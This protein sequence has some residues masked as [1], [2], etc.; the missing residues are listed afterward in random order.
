MKVRILPVM[1][2]VGVVL[3]VSTSVF[4]TERAGSNPVADSNENG[5]GYDEVFSDE[6]QKQKDRRDRYICI[7]APGIGAGWLGM[8]W[9]SWLF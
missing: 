6:D 7:E 5:E 2:Y 4:Q 8:H 3:A 9:R 1:P